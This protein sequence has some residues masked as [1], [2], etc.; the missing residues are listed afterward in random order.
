MAES[1]STGMLDDYGKISY[2][3]LIPQFLLYYNCVPVV[4]LNKVARPNVGMVVGICDK[5]CCLYTTTHHSH[6]VLKLTLYM[7][8]F[9][10]QENILSN[11]C[12]LSIITK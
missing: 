5:Q 9:F 11:Y 8:G 3:S 2:D 7:Y 4:W 12:D 6:N 1:I 10:F